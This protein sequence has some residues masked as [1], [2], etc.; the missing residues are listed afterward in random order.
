MDWLR[1]FLDFSAWGG[2]H[3][4]GVTSR[5]P[6]TVLW[7]CAALTRIG[8]AHT[9]TDSVLSDRYHHT[10]HIVAPPEPSRTR[11]PATAEVFCP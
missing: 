9:S 4:P 1:A 5:K 7:Q 3:L 8:G 2:G 6:R 11:T 10:A